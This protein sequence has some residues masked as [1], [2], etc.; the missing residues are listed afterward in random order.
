P[1]ILVAY[2]IPSQP[3]QPHTITFPPPNFCVPSTSLSFNSSPTSFQTHFLPSDPM[4]L[5]LVSSDHITCF[6]S[7]NVHSRWLWAKCNRARWWAGLRNGRFF[8]TTG[9]KP[10]F[11]K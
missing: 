10:V 6:Q 5:I 2:P 8:F 1:S 9:L 3:I 4:R 7:S 11:L